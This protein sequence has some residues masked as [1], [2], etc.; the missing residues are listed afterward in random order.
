MYIVKFYVHLIFV[1]LSQISFPLII[2]VKSRL[3]FIIDEGIHLR[4]GNGRL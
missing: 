2:L 1:S 3:S 4:E